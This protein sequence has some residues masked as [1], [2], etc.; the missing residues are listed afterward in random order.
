MAHA[1]SRAVGQDGDG[2]AAG[3]TAPAKEAVHG[4]GAHV[5][6]AGRGAGSPVG[7]GCGWCA[8]SV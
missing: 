1:M 2:R 5:E 7:A 3:K 4:Q 6:E 8:C